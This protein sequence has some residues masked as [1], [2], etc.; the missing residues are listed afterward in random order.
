[1]L[2][3][4]WGDADALRD[5]PTPGGRGSDREAVRREQSERF[6]AAI[7]ASCA[8]KGYEATSVEDLVRISGSSR[9]TF[10]EHFEDKLHC[11]RVAEEAIIAQAIALTA[12]RLEGEGDPVQR[13]RA[14]LDAFVELLVAQPAAARM[15]LVDAYSAGEAAI[16]P[17]HAAIDR[18]VLLVRDALEQI[19]G[20]GSMPLELVRGIVG[21][22]HQVIYGRL[23]EHGEAELPG[24][25]AGIWD[26]AMSF[27]PPPVPLRRPGRLVVARP[28][29]AAAPF[30][31]YSVEQRIIRALAV[32]VAAKGY[33]GT[34]VADV[35][36]EAAISQ[37]TFY[38][39][40]DGKADALIAALE[41]SGGQLLGAVLPA[42]R[43]TGDWRMAMRIG[44]EEICGFLA[45]EPAFA[46]MRSVDVYAA[47]PEA[48]AV[49]ERTGVQIITELGGPA[50][51]ERGLTL[52]PLA[53][54]A[55][56]GAIYAILFEGVRAGRTAELPRLAPYLTYFALVPFLGAEEAAEVATSRDRGR[57]R[58]G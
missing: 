52:S 35:V 23:R 55:S 34:T 8:G 14:A 24:L 44:F 10:Y 7:V 25:V 48:I 26:W 51:E 46:S 15:C 57:T 12:A 38:E 29:P 13:A 18:I 42:V 37:T 5:R 54:E 41:S 11:F 3:T 36:A 20:R 19:H 22:F 49:R 27:P 47:G 56:S 28:I 1:V 50:F 32:T 43:R 6:M 21:G 17:V 39:Y 9:T 30:A 53:N 33:P 31:S 4:P 40:F 16:G 58:P 45:A 2:Q